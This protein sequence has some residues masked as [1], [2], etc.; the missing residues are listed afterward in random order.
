MKNRIVNS[1][2]SI[3]MLVVLMAACSGAPPTAELEEPV[4]TQ[5]VVTEV[6]ANTEIEIELVSTQEV[7]TEIPANTETEIVDK[8]PVIINAS[9]HSTDLSGYAW[10]QEFQSS[11]NIAAANAKSWSESARAGAVCYASIAPLNKSEPSA[12]DGGFS[13]KFEAEP[14]STF[15]LMCDPDDTHPGAMSAEVFTVPADGG[16]INFITPGLMTPELGV[17]N[18]LA[19]KASGYADAKEMFMSAGTCRVFAFPGEGASIAV[20]D[21]EAYGFYME[22]PDTAGRVTILEN[23][24][25]AGAYIVL[26][27]FRA[28]ETEA[29]IDIALTDSSGAGLTWPTT[30]C[31]IKKGFSTDLVI[32]PG[33]E[34]APDFTLPDNE[35][36]MVSLSGMLEENEHVVL[37]FYFGYTCPPCMAQLREIEN[38]RAQ[39]EAMGAQIVGIAVQNERGARTS[40]ETSGA[41][42]PILA[43]SDRSVAKA[44]GVDDAGLSTPSVFVID[45][46]GHVIWKEITVIEGMGCGTERVPS[47]AILDVLSASAN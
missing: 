44:Y 22:A 33:E 11:N 47:Q 38:D 17:T 29:E 6:S 31:P 42:F 46:D 35:G 5:I 36:N 39:Y 37:V 3:I 10:I 2:G 30:S 15:R 34:I 26:K 4:S 20:S 12:A 8:V 28:D 24:S 1:I 7:A 25:R 21:G 45:R 18:E 27:E 14:G 40:A 41:E 13:F 32:M 43:D 9:V 16:T 23:P 19:A